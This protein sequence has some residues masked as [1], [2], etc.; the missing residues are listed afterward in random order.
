[1]KNN[2]GWDGFKK[3]TKMATVCPHCGE[4][5]KGE[6]YR[7]EPAS[8]YSF[9]DLVFF[10]ADCLH[11]ATLSFRPKSFEVEDESQ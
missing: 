5:G 7:L 9:V 6:S 11:R 4:E 1:M 2:D 8:D 10:C 3:E